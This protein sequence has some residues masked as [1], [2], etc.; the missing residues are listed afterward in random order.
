VQPQ[1]R[2]TICLPRVLRDLLI[3]EL[4]RG[5]LLMKTRS[6]IGGLIFA[7][8]FSVFAFERFYLKQ[9]MDGA[10]FVLAVAGF[11]LLYFAQAQKGKG[12]KS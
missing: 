4:K 3:S 8:L 9:Y 10:F 7:A 6:N 12:Q 11:L 2:G 1:K 5:Q